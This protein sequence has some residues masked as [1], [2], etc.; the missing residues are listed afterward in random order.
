[1]RDSKCLVWLLFFVREYETMTMITPGPRSLSSF[2]PS[3]N[4][5]IVSLDQGPRESCL[6]V[7]RLWITS[8]WIVPLDRISGIM[9]LDHTPLDHVTLDRVSGSWTSGIMS[10][11]NAPLD[12]VT[13]DRATGPHLGNHV[14]G[15][16]ASGSR[17]WGSCHWTASRDHILGSSQL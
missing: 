6:W 5:W 4:L 17:P 14:S 13:L 11:D 10:L 15:S 1:M 8:L 7:T 12:H 9:S 16:R 2:S 3:L